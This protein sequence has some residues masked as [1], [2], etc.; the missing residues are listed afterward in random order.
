MTDPSDYGSDAGSYTELLVVPDANVLV[1]GKP[2]VA[3]PWAELGCDRIE[4]VFVPPVIRELD[5]LKN[6][7]GRPNKIARQLSADVRTLLDAPLRT[8]EVRRSEPNVRK[9]VELRTITT[10]LHAGLDLTHADQALINYALHLSQDGTNV[11]LLTDDTIC[12]TTAAEFGLSVMLLPE[13]WLRDPEPD[14]ISRENARLSAELRRLTNTEPNIVITFSD[15]NGTTITRL[16]G[17]VTRWPALSEDEVENL[18]EEV[19]RLCPATQ[20]IAAPKPTATRTAA[21]QIE[22]LASLG[23]KTLYE[24]PTA[25]EIEEYQLRAYPDWLDAVR[26]ELRTLHHRLDVRTDWPKAVAAFANE[27]TRPARDTLLTIEA[28]GPFS[29]L[30][31]AEDEESSGIEMAAVAGLPTLPLPP[32]PPKGRTRTI[33]PLFGSSYLGTDAIAEMTQPLRTISSVTQP[34]PRH[35]DAFYWRKGSHGWVDRMEL[36]CVSWRHGQNP[37]TFELRLSPA[38]RVE[39]AG[40]LEVSVHAENLSNPQFARLPVRI[41]VHEGSTLERAQALVVELGRAARNS[42]RH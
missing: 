11:L 34:K 1:H 21:Q 18:M 10:S 31:E 38:E 2:L 26:D 7:T 37:L 23:S 33:H 32:P 24:P 4:V 27:G 6:Q 15:E 30:D 25:L 36:E 40:A 8:A 35:S 42:V 16:E 19:V 13:A 28:K 22:Q 17:R 20:S 3:L 9:R 14:E 29:I 12:A 5:K 41:S 39:T